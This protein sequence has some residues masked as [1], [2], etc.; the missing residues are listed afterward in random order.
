MRIINKIIF[1]NVTKVVA[2]STEMKQFL[3]QHRQGL[4]EQK[5]DVISNWY[6]DK[7][8]SGEKSTVKNEL[9]NS[10][11]ANSEFVVSYFGNLG[12]CQDLDTILE[13][14][15]KL[16]GD[17]NVKFIFAGHGNKMETLKNIIEKEKLDNV[18][19]FGFLHGQD[20]Q[21]ALNISDC[22]LV[23]LAEGVTGLGVPSKTYSYMMVGKPIIAIMG[24]DSDI[25]RDL[26]DNNAGYSMQ[27]GE[28][29]KLV[30][31]IK[32][33]RDNNLKQEIMG[34]NCR[35]IFL[36]KYT[37]EICTQKYIDMMKNI[38]GE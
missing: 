9:L 33:L 2:I 30:S 5:I 20:F 36:K 26:I 24:E 19:V 8:L 27:V 10:I 3:L 31:A 15:R 23:S 1:R 6:E 28:S 18:Y 25:T 11:K 22:F 21:D 29:M 17:N 14:I 16:K 13:A 12:I 37:K 32:E 38:I 34:E 35:N 7:K 4:S